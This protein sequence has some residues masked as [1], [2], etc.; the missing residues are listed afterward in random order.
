MR[1]A[2]DR[3]GDLDFP[4]RSA[5]RADSP[6]RRRRAGGAGAAHPV[7]QHA[8]GYVRFR[9]L[10]LCRASTT[11]RTR[12]V[13]AP[14]SPITNDRLR[15]VAYAYFEHNADPAVVPRLLDALKGERRSSS[16]GADARAR[17]P[18]SR[19]KVARR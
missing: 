15:T 8:D 12:D 7:K 11:A 18:C 5:A 14:R 10:V 9:A 6:P 1:S 13:M 17:R 19:P 3:L 16:P 4:I 2:I